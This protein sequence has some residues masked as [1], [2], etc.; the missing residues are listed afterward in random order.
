MGPR[1]NISLSGLLNAIDGVTS[2]EGRILIMTTNHPQLL[3][4]ALIRPGRVDMHITF[5][6]PSSVQVQE[7][8]LSIY[9]SS[10]ATEANDSVDTKRQSGAKYPHWVDNAALARDFAAVLCEK[11]NRFSLAA[12]QG[13]LLRHK[14][15][16]AA[17]VAGAKYWLEES[18]PGV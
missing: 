6:L 13:Y 4:S 10:E 16:P 1:S 15:D 7:L 14:R 2:P 18:Q 11:G 5:E 12:I 9:R 3:D 17:A 8:F